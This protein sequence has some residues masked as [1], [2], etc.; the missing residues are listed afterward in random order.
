MK[1]ILTVLFMCF[2][3]THPIKYKIHY[4]ESGI[5]EES[6]TLPSKL[7]EDTDVYL[8]EKLIIHYKE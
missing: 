5:V 4:L 8:G 3:K 1:Y 2:V 7:N 6:S